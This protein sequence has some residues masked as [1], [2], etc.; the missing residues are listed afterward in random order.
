MVSVM[1]PIR[2]FPKYFSR[3]HP[4]WQLD[5]SGQLELYATHIDNIPSA[6]QVA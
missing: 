4:G 3:V 2:G 1:V 6:L 5:L